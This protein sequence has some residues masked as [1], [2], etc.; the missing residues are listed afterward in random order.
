MTGTIPS[1]DNNPG[2]L[3]VAHGSRDPAATAA[4][5]AIRRAISRAA[6][7]L[8]VRVAYLQ[9]ATPSLA[10]E[11]AGPGPGPVVVPLLL[12]DGYHMATDIAAAARLAGTPVGTALGPDPRLTDVLADRLAEAGVPAWV[13]VVLA[14]AGSADPRSALAAGAQASLLAARLGVPVVPAFASAGLPTVRQAVA[15]LRART[16]GPVAVASY[17]VAPGLFHRCLT[18]SGADWVTEPL[19]AHPALASLVIDRYLTAARAR[20]AAADNGRREFATS[21]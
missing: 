18:D 9:H 2:L 5:D 15:E 19:G 1:R 11:L 8:D 14:A 21:R 13:P 20:P 7:V 3:A 16:A 6:P 12:S 4:I 10:D 17:L